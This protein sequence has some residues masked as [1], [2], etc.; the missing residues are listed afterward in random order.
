M[1]FY[2]SLCNKNLLVLFAATLIFHSQATFG[3]Q[4]KTNLDIRIPFHNQPVI[5]DGRPVVY[6]ELYI[7]NFGSDSIQLKTLQISD[8]K[9]HKL[10]ASINN[11]ELKNRSGRIGT[12]GKDNSTILP[13]GSSY[14]VYMELDV[15]DQDNAMLLSH[16]LQFETSKMGVISTDSTTITTV[17]K[18][19]DHLPVIGPPLGGGDR[20]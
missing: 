4:Y 5:I 2:L 11:D 16:S 8:L 17:M 7:T 15:K 12:Q 1:V 9:N 19:K 18:E 14:V 13:S 6:Y 10:L 20:K 3:Q